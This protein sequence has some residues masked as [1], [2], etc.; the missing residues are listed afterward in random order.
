[1]IELRDVALQIGG[2]PLLTGINARIGTGEFVA[3][4][5]PNG[6]GKTTLL[7]SIA[8]LHKPSAGTIFIDGI[9]NADLR[10]LERAGRVAF[11]TGDEAVFEA[12]S[13]AEVVATGRI[14]YHRWWQ[15]RAGADDERAI[16]AALASVRLD[17]FA[18]R[19]FSTLSAGERQRVWIALG[20]AQ[21][22][23]ILLLDEPTS[24]LDVRV[25]HEILELLH[26][27]ARAGKTIVCALHDVNEA[28]AYA[29]RIAM[30]GEGRLLEFARPDD[31]LTG[32]ALERV[33]GI[34]MERVRTASGRLRA[35]VL[36]SDRL[37]VMRR[38][39]VRTEDP[40]DDSA[41]LTAGNRDADRIVGRVKERRNDVVLHA[42]EHLSVRAG[43]D[44]ERVRQ[45]CLGCVERGRVVF[46][47]SRARIPNQDGRVVGG[48]VKHDVNAAMHFAV[49]RSEANAGEPEN[50]QRQHRLT[51]RRVLH[52]A[53]ESRESRDRRAAACRPA[54]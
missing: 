53:P 49:G 38:P 7:R 25:A 42:R 50:H 54:P 15:W 30:L 10:P 4:L 17:A 12:L 18:R 16:A 6:V 1:M 32:P 2:H 26:G 37:L 46:A 5:G 31:L 20:L 14:P 21:E 19:L 34:R 43:R 45:H 23:P 29:D 52:R 27:L 8:G 39:N 11:V 36:G 44:E 41:V 28:A 13:V 40:A 35:F 47:Q 9:A 3:V 22:T 33:Y 24:H 48:A 51:H